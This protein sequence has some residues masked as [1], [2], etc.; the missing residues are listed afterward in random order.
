MTIPLI[1]SVL[2]SASVLLVFVGLA[3]MRPASSL[4]ERIELYSGS[5]PAGSAPMTLEQV[6]LQQ[7]FM[8]R[9]LKPMILRSMHALGRMMPDKQLAKLRQR[10]ALAGEPGNLTPA[11][12]VGIKIWTTIIL[13]SLVVLRVMSDPPLSPLMLGAL[14]GWVFM[15]FR[16]PDIWLSRRIKT[17][18]ELLTNQMPDALDMLTIGVEAG[19]SFDQ[20]VDEIVNRWSNELSGEF[21]R[22]LYEIGVGTSRR[23]A[24]EHLKE[25]TGVRDIASFVVAINHSEEL[26]TSMGQVLQTQSEEMRTR[27]RQRAQEK[28]N[29]V[30]IKMMFPLTMFIFPAMFA[31]ILGPAIPQIMRGLAMV[32]Q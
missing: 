11:Q 18:Q 9:V 21:R 13:A 31:V 26:G 5:A 25:R 3:T 20:S 4:R 10:L 8:Q 12:F 24:L 14:V 15:G 19:L 28:A 7:S 30:P 2:F 6:E 22:V 17:R 1:A 23:V 29:K 27:R 16:L 32:G